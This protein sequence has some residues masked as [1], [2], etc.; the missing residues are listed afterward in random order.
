[1]R[2]TSIL[3][4]LAIV[5]AVGAFSPADANLSQLRAALDAH[6]ITSAQLVQFYLDRIARFDKAGARINAILTLNPS[7][8]E[9]ARRRDADATAESVRRAV[10]SALNEQWGNKPICLVHVLTI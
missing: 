9:Q 6:E 8:P 1:M 3:I 2:L 5:G 7:A 10:R 4:L